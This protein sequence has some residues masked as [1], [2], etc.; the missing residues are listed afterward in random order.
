[1]TNALLVALPVVG[2]VN[3]CFGCLLYGRSKLSKDYACFNWILTVSHFFHPQ[4]KNMLLQINRWKL[5]V[6]SSFDLEGILVCLCY[7]L[8]FLLNIYY[9]GHVFNAKDFTLCFYVSSVSSV[10]SS[11][12]G[13]IREKYYLLLGC[14]WHIWVI[15]NLMFCSPTLREIVN[16]SDRS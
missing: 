5:E 1:M 13:A 12:S 14:A 16:M 7:I 6:L 9:Y 4:V 2:T 3:C 15:L 10:I 8:L 11:L